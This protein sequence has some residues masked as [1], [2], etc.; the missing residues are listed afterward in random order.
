MLY[1]KLEKKLTNKDIEDTK[2]Y[3]RC[4]HNISS[5][6]RFYLEN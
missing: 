4:I 6:V 2:I 1:E 5:N 3:K